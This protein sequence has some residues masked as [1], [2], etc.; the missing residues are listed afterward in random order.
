MSHLDSNQISE[1]RKASED[2]RKTYSRKVCERLVQLVKNTLRFLSKYFQNNLTTSTST[3]QESTASEVVF[4]LRTYLSLPN[5]EVKPSADDIQKVLNVVGQTIISVNKGISQ[6]NNVLL[7]NRRVRSWEPVIQWLALIIFLAGI[8][9]SV[10][11]NF[12]G[13][14]WVPGFYPALDRTNISQCRNLHHVG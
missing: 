1:I 7:D 2:L 10:V 8:A 9:F 5:V 14:T 12:L 6:W 11:W 4:V 13:N 3:G